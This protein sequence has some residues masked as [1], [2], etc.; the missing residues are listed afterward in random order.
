MYAFV[1]NNIINNRVASNIETNE[2]DVLLLYLQ[3][4]LFHFE[5]NSAVQHCVIVNTSKKIGEFFP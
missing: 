3:F 1:G 5:L 2:I 4:I